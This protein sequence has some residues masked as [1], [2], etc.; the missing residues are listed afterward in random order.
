MFKKIQFI[1]K[2]V[3][4]TFIVFGCFVIL[5]IFLISTKEEV[6][7]KKLEEQTWTVS[8]VKAKEFTTLKVLKKLLEQL[9]LLDMQI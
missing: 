1:M 7:N 4:P 6:E 9:K 3:L 5:Y 2:K 8:L